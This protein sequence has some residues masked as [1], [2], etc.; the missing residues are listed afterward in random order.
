MMN[1]AAFNLYEYIGFAIIVLIL[2]IVDAIL[3]NI[4]ARVVPGK[5]YYRVEY[6]WWVKWIY[7]RVKNFQYSLLIHCL[8]N[9]ILVVLCV[10]LPIKAGYMLLFMGFLIARVWNIGYKAYVYARGLI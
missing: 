2:G 7:S 8:F 6:L 10:L 4:V 9:T 3:T 1:L 5:N